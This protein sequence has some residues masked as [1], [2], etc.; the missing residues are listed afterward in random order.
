M[1]KNYLFGM[2]ALAAMTMVGCSNDEVVNDYSQDNAIQ[3]GTYVGRDA[4]SR[5]QVID[6]KVLGE[7]GFGVFAFFTENEEFDDQKHT[8]N[9]MY[10]QK[11]TA[12]GWVQ[13]TTD[14]NGNV[15]P[16]YYTNWTY[17]P[18]KYWPNDRGDKVSF[19]AYAPYAT[20][21]NGI[22]ISGAD[23]AGVPTVTYKFEPNVDGLITI[24]VG[25]DADGMVDLLY[26]KN[27]SKE[28][29][30]L[31]KPGINDRILFKFGHALSR[32][33]FAAKVLVDEVG[34]ENNGDVEGEHEMTNTLAP[35][36]TITIN[37]VKLTGKFY[38][39]GTMSLLDGS[40]IN[41]TGGEQEVSFYLDKANFANEQNE[42]T[43]SHME[44]KELLNN[45]DSYIMLFPQA[46]NE[47][48]KITVTV[49][50]DVVTI[51]EKN[52]SNSSNVKNVYTSDEFIINGAFE[53]GHAYKLVLHLGM[54]SVK[55]SAELEEWEESEHVVNVPDNKK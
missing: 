7:E 3:F 4:E 54:T 30:D 15:T 39:G 17:T 49:G 13:E 20:D 12:T 2:L 14:D 50:Y 53:Q 24:P 11:V 32:V 52:S 19:F 38:T 21:Q 51:D 43:V 6:T 29:I 44:T 47:N 35:E 34:D 22:E 28:I 31:E 41:N 36:T 55:V 48:N 8:P 46:L 26:L 25:E 37:S 45:E 10:N 33:S 18:V 16:G 42:F 23:V 1:K 9:F 5:A 40:W 27:E